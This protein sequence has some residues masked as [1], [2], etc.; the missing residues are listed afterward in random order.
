MYLFDESLFILSH[1]FILTIT[2]SFLVY[3]KAC[4]TK[5]SLHLAPFLSSGIKWAWKARFESCAGKLQM[6]KLETESTWPIRNVLRKPRP[7]ITSYF[8]KHYVPIKDVLNGK[9]SSPWFSLTCGV[10]TRA[11]GKYPPKSENLQIEYGEYILNCVY[12]SNL[13]SHSTVM[14]I[15]VHLS[16]NTH[17]V[18]QTEE[19]K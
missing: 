1:R 15:N 17:C 4:S 14:L 11:Q 6:V 9:I 19:S 7:K 3:S 16:M 18:G 13:S 2:A 5:T 10:N 12:L 8:Q